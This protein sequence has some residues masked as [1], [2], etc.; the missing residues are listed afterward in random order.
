MAKFVPRVQQ[1]AFLR[2]LKQVREDRGL[3]QSQLAAKIKRPQSFVS[4]VESGE[5]RLDVLELRLVCKGIGITLSEFI[6]RL[7]RQLK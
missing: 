7:E 2:M 5:R 3:T 1:D 4:K 6:E